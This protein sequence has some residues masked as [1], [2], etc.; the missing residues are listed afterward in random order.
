M[1]YKVRDM[2]SGREYIWSIRQMISEINRDRSDTWLPYDASD[3]MEGWKHWVEGEAFE[4][5]SR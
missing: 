1:K 3:W 5:V 2:E 4:I